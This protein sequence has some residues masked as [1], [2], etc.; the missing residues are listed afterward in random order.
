MATPPEGTARTALVV[1]VTGISG[2]AL[3]ERLLADGWTVYGVSRSA[4]LD[5]AVQHVPADVLDT[6]ALRDAVSALAPTHV[7]FTVWSRQETEAENIRVNGGIVRE[8]LD[9]LAPAGSVRHCALVTGLKHYIGPFEAYG[10]GE[11]RETPFHE[12]EPRL[13]YPNFYYAQEDEVF[14]AAERQ[15]FSWS[16]HRAHTVIG[17]VTG[18]A[19]NMALTLGA[20]AALCRWSGRPLYFPGND[21][22]WNGLTDMTDA[23]LMAEQL[24]WASTADGAQNEAY[25]IANGD[26]FRWRWMWPRLAGLLGVDTEPFDGTVRPLTEQMAELQDAWPEVVGEHGLRDLGIDKVASWWHTDGDL[27]RPIE[28]LTDMSKSRKAGFHG[29]RCTLDSFAEAFEAYRAA[30]ILP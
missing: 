19:M 22:Q 30:K 6:A 4:P 8:V 26:V 16:V 12:E 29:Y 27:G 10:L 7:F 2:A 18:N 21:V 23:S 24:I 11:V 14:A 20:A 13:P 15:G 1:G 28:C 3:A 17:T 5:D 25:N 9:S